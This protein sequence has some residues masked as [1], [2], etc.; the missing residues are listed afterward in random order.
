MA[1]CNIGN[2]ASYH[3]GDFCLYVI[4]IQVPMISNAAIILVGEIKLSKHLVKFIFW[5]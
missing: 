5:L 1:T 3:K 4:F 2:L